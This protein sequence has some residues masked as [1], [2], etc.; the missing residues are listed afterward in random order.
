[1]QRGEPA[2]GG[3]KWEN[4]EEDG[5]GVKR[6]V[7]PGCQ[8]W[9]ASE[10][11]WIPQRR[12]MLLDGFDNQALPGVVFEQEVG[13]QFVVRHGRMKLRSEGLPRGKGEK[14]VCGNQGL[15]A[16]RDGEEEEGGQQKEYRD[17]QQIRSSH[18][19][20]PRAPLRARSDV[21]SES[22]ARAARPPA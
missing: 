6:A 21:A 2:I 12:L 17:Q 4:I 13:E 7:L 1:M 15:P 11:V 18:A 16:E 3:F 14:V 8:E 10:Q 22:P 20:G 19:S 9:H 5:K